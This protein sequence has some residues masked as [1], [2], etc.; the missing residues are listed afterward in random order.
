MHYFI[1]MKW[2]ALWSNNKYY[3]NVMKQ[4]M[5]TLQEFYDN[6]YFIHLAGHCDFHL[7][8]TIK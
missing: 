3:F 1:D 6:N 4:K 8:P 7:I 5:L 2:N